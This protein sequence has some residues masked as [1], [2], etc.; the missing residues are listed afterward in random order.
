MLLVED[1]RRAIDVTVVVPAVVPAAPTASWGSDAAPATEF[2]AV[3]ATTAM[4]TSATEFTAVATTTVTAGGCADATAART[5]RGCTAS[6]I[7]CSAVAA[8][9]R[10]DEGMI[11][12]RITRMEHQ[13]TSMRT[14]TLRQASA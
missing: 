4:A 5:A 12:Q 9:V 13:M 3:V 11:L 2:T 8:D 1:R 10:F 6:A 7:C 14:V